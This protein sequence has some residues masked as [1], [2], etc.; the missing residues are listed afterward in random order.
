M[1][2]LSK[3]ILN[4]DNLHER[5]KLLKKFNVMHNNIILLFSFFWLMATFNSRIYD[6]T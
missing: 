1:I 4:D 3:S 6:G 5:S 2:F